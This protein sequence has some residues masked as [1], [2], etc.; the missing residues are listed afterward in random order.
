MF[1]RTKGKDHNRTELKYLGRVKTKDKRV[2]KILTSTWYW[3]LSPRATSNI[4]VYNSKNQYLGNYYVTM[5]NDLPNK[6]EKNSLVLTN[7]DD[8]DCDA[9]IVTRISF[10][11]RIPKSI[12]LKCK[13]KYGS[14]Y[15]FQN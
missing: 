13:G 1:D 7:E 14:I 10:R 12:F 15:S 3:G 5:T 11:Y 6:I 4:W 9:K 2:F 8:E